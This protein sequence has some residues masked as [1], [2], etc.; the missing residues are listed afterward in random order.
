MK[1]KNIGFIALM[2]LLAS[3]QV[4]AEEEKDTA[5]KYNLGNVIVSATKTEAYQ[6]EVG[7]STTVIT[8]E[9]LKR[10]GKTT[11]G[12]VLRGVTG[13]AA[14]QNGPFG[15]LTSIYLRGS[16]PG[17]TLVMVDG[18]EINDSISADRSF[19]FANLAVDNIERIEVIRGAQSTLYG[20]DAMGGVINII[21]KKGKGKPKWEIS[22]EAGS[23]DT[24]KEGIGLTGEIEKLN[25]S[26]SFSR[27]DSDGISK[28]K[29]GVE[30]D[31][32]QNFTI[33][34]RLGYRI[35]NDAELSLILR[36]TNAETDIDDGAYEDDPNYTIWSKNLASKFEF[37]QALRPWWDHKLSFSYSETRRKHRDEKD[38][39]DTTE[40]AQ[41]WF[42]GDNKKIEW[43]HNFSPVSWDTLTGGFEYEQE[44]GSSYS[45]SRTIIT[46]IDRKTVSNTG[47]Y[48]QNQFRLWE[49]LFITP[50]LR[51]DEHE[52][53]GTETTYKISTAYL[54]PQTGTRLKA[55][56]ATGFKAP[57]LF[58]LYSSFGDP[59]LKPD[60]SK[61]YDFGFEQ[62]L[63]DNLV[64][65]GATYFHNKFKDMVDFDIAT[66]KYK[67]I[68][69]AIT[70]G[71]E[72]ELIFKPIRDLAISV[73]YTYLAAEDK[74]IGKKLAR[75][76]ENQLNFNLNWSFLEKAN[77]N[78]SASYTGHT[79]D[80][81]ANT[82]K[83]KGY[84]KFDL[85]ASYGLTKNFQIFG[86]INNLLD[87]DYQEIRGFAT[88]GRSFYIGG[89]EAF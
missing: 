11:V 86:R 21:T 72:T 75:R 67:N 53:F 68:D 79:W 66:S 18:V 31:G 71:I 12:E 29:D 4:W 8:A 78:L 70:K 85:S 81:A 36:Y 17:H 73:N 83:V 59:N 15:G 69:N 47:F 41:S 82:R 2:I 64:T 52:L 37:T 10:I 14:A 34:S 57:S 13:V 80:N 28:A 56:W 35:L 26:F 1:K 7:S 76:P 58:Q 23:H 32:Y 74:D 22:T 51:V 6:A 62:N 48:L 33:S 3:S 40:D 43:Q 50:G 25:Y 39:V 61:G 89:K 24:F 88:E 20:S 54:I 63:W 9:E 42:K 55:N 27:L 49:K 84:P 30:K 77:L 44:R 46:K 38:I 65:F 5:V 60:K 45:R 19:D 16:K 87:R